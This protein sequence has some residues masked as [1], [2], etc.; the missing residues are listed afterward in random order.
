VM[1]FV[2]G[3]VWVEGRLAAGPGDSV[4]FEGDGVQGMHW[5]PASAGSSSNAGRQLRMALRHEHLL[6]SDAPD[7]PGWDGVRVELKTFLGTRFRYRCVLASG[8]R[9]EF[10]LDLQAAQAEEGQLLSL[11]FEPAQAR[12]FDALTGWALT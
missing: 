3:C 7:L 10:D 5:L 6:R 8:N 11:R 1:D 2:G 12:F 4:S 9:L